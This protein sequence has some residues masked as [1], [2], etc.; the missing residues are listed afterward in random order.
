[1]CRQ[2]E[3]DITDDKPSVESRA[4]SERGIETRRRRVMMVVAAQPVMMVAVIMPG[5]VIMRVVV[6]MVMSVGLRHR[7]CS[8]LHFWG[9]DKR[10]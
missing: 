4:N 9:S 7:F 2:A 10:W 5:A 1:V 3:D 8:R 6:A